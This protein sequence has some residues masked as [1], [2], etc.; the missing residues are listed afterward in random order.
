MLPTKYQARYT[1]ISMNARSMQVFC[2]L[3]YKQRASP[4][5]VG[6]VIERL[7]EQGKEILEY[8]A[9]DGAAQKERDNG[10]LGSP[11]ALDLAIQVPRKYFRSRSFD[12]S[13]RRVGALLSQAGSRDFRKYAGMLS[14]MFD[15]WSQTASARAEHRIPLPL[16]TIA[17]ISERLFVKSRAD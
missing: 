1:D 13:L 6:R 16:K 3:A 12:G 9:D 17:E 7:R 2:G 5:V 14:E 15:E 10:L 8:C 11:E 4:K